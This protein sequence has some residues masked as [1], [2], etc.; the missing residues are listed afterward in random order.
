MKKSCGLPCLGSEYGNVRAGPSR[1]KHVRNPRRQL[2][3]FNRQNG[4][5][6]WPA[7]AKV[8]RIP[9]PPPP[10]ILCSPFGGADA[11][12][13]HVYTNRA[14]S[15]RITVSSYAI[16]RI[17]QLFN[18][19]RPTT[20]PAVDRQ[21]REEYAIRLHT[22]SH[23][24]KVYKSQ[25]Q[26]TVRWIFFCRACCTYTVSQK[27]G[28]FLPRCMECRRGLTMRFLSI[29]LSVCLSVCPSV[30]RVHCDKTEER[31]V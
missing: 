2:F 6:K 21:T 20:D 24:Y 30:K 4:R 14:R 28:T 11:E 13:F 22:F 31:Y 26:C 15:S 1:G 5:S 18:T 27:R 23:E 8:P 16:R 29:C 7:A 9:P 19:C 3:D 25:L 17:N 12:P 10:G